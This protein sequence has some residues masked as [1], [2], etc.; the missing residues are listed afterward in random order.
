M[1][2]KGELMDQIRAEAAVKELLLAL[3]QDVEIEGYL[4]LYRTFFSPFV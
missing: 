2:E 3:D 1:E 4:V